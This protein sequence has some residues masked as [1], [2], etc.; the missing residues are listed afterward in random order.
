MNGN[1]FPNDIKS[2]R[3]RFLHSE[4][5]SDVQDYVVL[6]AGMSTS[7]LVK[8]MVEAAESRSYR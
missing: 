3:N 2:M 7:L 6:S 5:V 1:R 8:K 4:D